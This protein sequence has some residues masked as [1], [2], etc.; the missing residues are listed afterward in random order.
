MTYDRRTNPQSPVYEKQ[1]KE[2]AVVLTRY[3]MAARGIDPRANW[4]KLP[5]EAQDS[6]IS[7]LDLQQQINPVGLVRDATQYAITALTPVPNSLA[8]EGMGL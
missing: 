2:M 7:Y 4:T 6:V 1:V 5:T 3:A 8:D